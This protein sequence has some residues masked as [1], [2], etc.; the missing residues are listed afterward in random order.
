MCLC[1]PY[2]QQRRAEAISTARRKQD[3]V[4]ER[5]KVFV[6]MPVALNRGGLMPTPVRCL[7]KPPRRVRTST[8]EDQRTLIDG[9]VVDYRNEK[10]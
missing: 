6:N 10:Q 3:A 8:H 9:A 7:T 4:W 2:A 1:I 5:R